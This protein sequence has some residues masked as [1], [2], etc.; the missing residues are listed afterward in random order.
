MNGRIN[1]KLK[2]IIASVLTIMS[3]TAC[4]NTNNSG[5]TQYRLP[6]QR[7][8]STVDEIKLEVETQG[9]QTTFDSEKR[10][11]TANSTKEANLEIIYYF[12]ET[13]KYRYAMSKFADTEALNSFVSQ[14]Q[15]EGFVLHAS[16][17]KNPDE[18]VYISTAKNIIIAVSTSVEKGRVSPSYTFGAID[19]TAFSWTRIEKLSDASGLWLPLIAKGLPLDMIYRFEARLGHS[20]NTVNT[21]E[22]SGVYSFDTGNSK[23]PQ[24]RYWLDVK[25]KL[26]LEEAAIFVNENNRP[27][28]TEVD[29]F[30]TSIGFK[31]TSLK[32]ENNNQIYYNKENKCCASVDMNKPNTGVF[33]PK[34][35]FFYSNIEDKLPLEKVDFPMPIVEFGTL[36]MQQ[37][38][39]KYKSQSYYVNHSDE[40][41]RIV[42]NTKSADFPEIWIM[43]GEGET[44]DKYSMAFVVTTDTRVIN[45]PNIPEILIENGYQKRDVGIIPT[46]INSSLNVMAQLDINGDF[47]AM[48]VAFS[49]NEF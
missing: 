43:A 2:T 5:S 17:S 35:Q 7:F 19:E 27:T 18:R 22:A 1:L 31:A 8:G 29:V 46:Y 39:D 10:Q 20:L 16:V 49:T 15:K 37:A 45:S 44:A 30:L 41:W 4:E 36:T 42:V 24:I 13:N 11:L 25:S 6:S 21:K 38:I 40:G 33:E 48:S 26:F 23:F 47:G 12:D 9:F 28:P 34:I 32:D 14:I 3:F